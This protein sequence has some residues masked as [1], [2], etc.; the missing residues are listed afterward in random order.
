MNG[1]K[2]KTE[3]DNGLAAHLTRWRKLAGGVR[4]NLCD[5]AHAAEHNAELH[6]LADEIL[7]SA[8]EQQALTARLRGLVQE[9]RAKVHRARDLRARLAA[10]VTGCY[11]PYSDKLREFGLKPRKRRRRGVGGR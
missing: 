7:R 3:P 4:N 1:K 8:G 10:A 2:K 11:G 9:R 6:R 5:L